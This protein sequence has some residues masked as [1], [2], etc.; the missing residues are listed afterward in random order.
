MLLN[1]P[2]IVAEF[3]LEAL[4]NVVYSLMNNSF[5]FWIDVNAERVLRV[6]QQLKQSLEDAYVLVNQER[7]R[8]TNGNISRKKKFSKSKLKC[9][10]VFIDTIISGL[11]KF[12]SPKV[13]RIKL[14]LKRDWLGML[15][16]ENI[17]LIVNGT[18]HLIILGDV[19]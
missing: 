13:L 4:D 16:L 6:K 5:C 2:S 14:K 19:S 1:I 7:K 10:F 17:F 8:E 9:Y 18:T 15:M 3:H 11:Y 12:N